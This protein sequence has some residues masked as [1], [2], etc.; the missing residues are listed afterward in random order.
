MDDVAQPKLRWYRM[1]PDRLILGL[2]AVEAFLLLSEWRCWLPLNQ[3]KGWTVLTAITAVGVTLMLLWIW[4]VIDM[5][6]RWRFRYSLRLL[7]VVAVAVPGGWLATEML[8][9]HR[10]YRA[11]AAVEAMGGEVRYEID[12]IS[13]WFE[14]QAP[15]CIVVLRWLFGSD[16]FAKPVAA[17]IKSDAGLANLKALSEIESLEL[18]GSAI[19]DAGLE[20]LRG[21]SQLHFLCLA[22]SN[23]TDAGLENI[24]SSHRLRFLYLFETKVTDSGLVHLRGLNQ[25]DSLS[26]WGACLNSGF[27]WKLSGRFCVSLPR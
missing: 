1:T 20:N 15:T 24:A 11:V 16:F 4:L 9:A 10:Q 7:L 13:T 19:T 3:Y 14:D 21:L 18:D 2:L 22:S 26:L 6:I 8:R 25:L 17:A 12:P 5:L 27:K 23:V